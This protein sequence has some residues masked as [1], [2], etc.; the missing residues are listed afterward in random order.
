M[1]L[2]AIENKNV[3]NEQDNLVRGSSDKS[4]FTNLGQNFEFMLCPPEY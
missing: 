2:A 3:Q 1:I 4:R